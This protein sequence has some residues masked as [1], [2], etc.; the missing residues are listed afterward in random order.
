MAHGTE[1][2]LHASLSME[3]NAISAMTKHGKQTNVEATKI[4]TQFNS[5]TSEAKVADL[6]EFKTSL[7]HIMSDR[8]TRTT[9]EYP[10]LQRRRRGRKRKREEGGVG[11]GGQQQQQYSRGSS[12]SKKRTQSCILAQHFI[13]N[14]KIEG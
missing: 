2:V 7:I 13:S 10:L 5:R 8:T 1:N 14:T 6:C 9:Q 12:G 3:I 11:G 4:L